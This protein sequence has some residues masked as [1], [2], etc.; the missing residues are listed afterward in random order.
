MRIVKFIARAGICSR[1]QAESLLIAKKI[2]INDKI[3]LSPSTQ[4]T[5]NDIV[6]YN[7]KIITLKALEVFLYYKPKGYITT[8]HD[9]QNRKTIYD[10][11][12]SYLHNFITVGRLDINSEGLLLLINDGEYKRFLELPRNKIARTYKVRI[13]G[14]F[15]KKHK[16]T[17]E[18][19]IHIENIL[20]QAKSVS[21]IKT[22][23]NSWLEVTL[24]EG[25]N[26]EIRKIFNHLGYQVNR[27]IRTA[28]GKYH[29]DNLKAGEYKQL[30]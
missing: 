27:L 12:P 13:Y 16:N 26:R 6:K 4:V 19:G 15:N 5:D 24:E 10:N 3:I 8:R 23:V 14:K 1:R 28:Y 17:I 9:P 7:G 29:L 25:K 18:K 22:G 21:I 30:F 11:L 2:T 20:Y